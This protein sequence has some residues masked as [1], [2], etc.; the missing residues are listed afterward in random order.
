ME[1][2][3]SCSPVLGRLS[4]L[5]ISLVIGSLVFMVLMITQRDQLS[6]EVEHLRSESIDK[7]FC[8]NLCPEYSN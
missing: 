3:R 6:Q 8:S 1:R 5:L 2:Y 4:C 7:Q